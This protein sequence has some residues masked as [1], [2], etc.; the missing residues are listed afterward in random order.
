MSLIYECDG[1]GLQTT[2][3]VVRG[4]R[5]LELVPFPDGWRKYDGHKQLYHYCSDHCLE[6]C[7]LKDHQMVVA[8]DR[9]P[10]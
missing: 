6:T 8:W 10:E 9:R 3:A 2:T 5:E 4:S 1:C 7:K